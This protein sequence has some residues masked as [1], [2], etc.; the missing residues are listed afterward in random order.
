MYTVEEVVKMLREGNLSR[1]EGEMA[2]DGYMFKCTAYNVGDQMIRIDLKASR[3]QRLM[4]EV[5]GGKL[6]P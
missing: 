2:I 3:S 4:D 1:I 5:E 6:V